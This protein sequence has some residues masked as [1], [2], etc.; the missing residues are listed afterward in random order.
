MRSDYIMYISLVPLVSLSHGQVPPDPMWDGIESIGPKICVVVMSDY[1]SWW[2]QTLWTLLV[3]LEKLPQIEVNI[4][5]NIW[6]QH[7]VYIYHIVICFHAV[8]FSNISSSQNFLKRKP[9]CHPHVDNVASR[10]YFRPTIPPMDATSKGTQ[11]T[12]I[13][14]WKKMS[15][16]GDTTSSLFSALYKCPQNDPSIFFWVFSTIQE[17]TQLISL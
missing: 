6:N 2:F 11:Q 9:L 12:G 14:S 8:S 4:K 16:D 3:K 13:N 17:T 10:G 1:T 15:C 5:K 7:L